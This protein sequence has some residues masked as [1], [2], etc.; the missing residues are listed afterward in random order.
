M[1]RVMARVAESGQNG[2][3]GEPLRQ[4]PW[5]FASRSEDPQA[6]EA[7]GRLMETIPAGYYVDVTQLFEDFGW[8]RVP[9]DR[10]WRS[11]FAGVLFW[12]FTKPDDLTWEDAMLQIYTQAEVEEFLAGI[13]PPPP[14]FIPTPTGIGAEEGE[15]LETSEAPAGAQPGIATAIPTATP[16]P[17]PGTPPTAIPTSG[18]N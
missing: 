3:L 8:E 12:E 11:N 5:D 14:T 15:P 17:L 13:V 18:G 9:S 7:G 16:S 1:W 6:F 2:G 4:L 10:T